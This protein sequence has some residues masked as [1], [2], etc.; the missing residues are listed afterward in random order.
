MVDEVHRGF[1]DA[2]GELLDFDAVELA[3]MYAG[4]PGDLKPQLACVSLPRSDPPEQLELESSELAV[5]DDQKVAAAAGR[6]EELEPGEPIVEAAQRWEAGAGFE[7][8]AQGLHEERVDGP[9]DVLLRQ[10]GDQSPAD[11]G[12]RALLNAVTLGRTIRLFRSGGTDTTGLRSGRPRPGTRLQPLPSPCQPGVAATR[13]AHKRSRRATP[14][15]R[16]ERDLE[17]GQHFFPP[18]RAHTGVAEYVRI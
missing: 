10:V 13:G 3:D 15:A 16:R 2:G 14:R 17:G 9:E 1:G 4:L 7:L 11:G 8:G 6:V 5:G 12:N 18:G